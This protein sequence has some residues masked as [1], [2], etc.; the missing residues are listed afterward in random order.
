MKLSQLVVGNFNL[1]YETYCSICRSPY[2]YLRLAICY[3]WCNKIFGVVAQ[4]LE[5]A[6]H[7]RLVVGSN[8]TRPTICGTVAQW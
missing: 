2:H 8:P 6:A 7:N 4:W 3:L 1:S 5:R